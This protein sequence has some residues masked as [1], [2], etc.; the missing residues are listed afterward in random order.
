MFAAQ[1]WM[2]FVALQIVEHGGYI[3][4]KPDDV[5]HARK[6]LERCAAAA[7]AAGVPCS[8]CSKEAVLCSV[9]SE[10]APAQRA[11]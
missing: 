3:L 2:L 6:M 11:P 1:L 4:E 5:S 8:M 7:A 10:F 9:C